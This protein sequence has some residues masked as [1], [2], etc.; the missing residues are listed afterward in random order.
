MPVSEMLGGRVIGGMY[1]GLFL[2]GVTS[3]WIDV[4]GALVLLAA[5]TIDILSRRGAQPRA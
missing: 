2:I 3:E 1:N 4:V 5:G